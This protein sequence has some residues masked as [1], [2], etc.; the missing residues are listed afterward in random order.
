MP[1]GSDR[2]FAWFCWVAAFILYA[3]LRAGGT[4]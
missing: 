3:V 4:L 2:D 1:A